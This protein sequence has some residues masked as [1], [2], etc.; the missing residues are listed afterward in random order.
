VLSAEISITNHLDV[1]APAEET[2][3]I[4]L[5]GPRRI[6]K[7]ALMAVCLKA[8]TESRL[9]QLAETTGRAP[10]ELV[11]DAM[12]G[13]LAE[14]T[15]A[16]DTLHGRCDDIK[17]GRVQP[18]MAKPLLPGWPKEQGPPQCRSSALC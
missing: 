9:R 7:L 1:T 6:P 4:A 2:S 11:E 14:L 5:T 3:Q 8:K 10:D 15:Q 18:S 13:Y 16:R 12:T 17:A